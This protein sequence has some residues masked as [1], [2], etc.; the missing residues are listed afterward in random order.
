MLR[1]IGVQ[2]RVIIADERN[3]VNMMVLVLRISFCV[4]NFTCTC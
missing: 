2:E 3:S 1:R 4:Q